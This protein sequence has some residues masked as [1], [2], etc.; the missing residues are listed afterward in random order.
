MADLIFTIK[1]PAELKGVEQAIA[2]FESAKG[3]ALA[4]GKSVEEFDAKIARAK[5]SIQAYNAAQAQSAQAANAAAAATSNQ[6]TELGQ[7]VDKT[8]DAAKET[9]ELTLKKQ[10]LSKIV[11]ALA[12]QF[13]LLG[14]AGRFALNP[15]VGA[16][17]GVLYV[18]NKGREDYARFRAELEKRAN[19]EGLK[20]PITSVTEAIK[21]ARDE[22]EKFFGAL[23][24]AATANSSLATS[25]DDTITAL[26]NQAEKLRE[27]DEAYKDH[28]LAVLRYQK[29]TGE[30]TPAEFEARELDVENEFAA[31]NQKR[32]ADLD[33]AR[34]AVLRE[35]LAAAEAQR[36]EVAPQIA[37]AIAAATDAEKEAKRIADNAAAARKNLQAQNELIAGNADSPG[38]Q[39]V[40]DDLG[41]SERDA[42]I[43]APF[44]D[45]PDYFKHQTG[46]LHTRV[47]VGAS[48]ALKWIEANVALQDARSK[49]AGIASKMR[50]LESQKDPAALEAGQLR[51]RAE[52]VKTQMERLEEDVKTLTERLKK[53]EADSNLNA[54]LRKEIERVKQSTR[55][56]ETDTQIHEENQRAAKRPGNQFNERDE[57]RAGRSGGDFSQLPTAVAPDVAGEFAAYHQQNVA[58]V[59]GLIAALRDGKQDLADLRM[60]NTDTMLS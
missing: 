55:G 4:A 25:A 37:P 10:E 2:G 22:T 35:K 12:R 3:K 48:T 26:N 9:G 39:K 34:Q 13:P 28:A 38:L 6:N 18:V 19:L 23:N 11:T 16:M 30:I 17:L 1:T 60:R 44:R 41:V 59:N 32:Q 53:A 54:P 49:Q 52:A 27:L 24:Q 5:A 29:A 56:I 31:R 51:S 43:M 36:R 58:L 21:D 45:L 7:E 14:L 46:P 47:H 57:N 33:A 40:R 42:E 20:G 8:K 50:E 15:I